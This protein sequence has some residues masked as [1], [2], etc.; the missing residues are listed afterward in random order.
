MGSGKDMIIT[1]NRKKF[2]FPL[3]VDI[4]TFVILSLYLWV[5]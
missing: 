3:F 4:F 5:I 2:N 1:I